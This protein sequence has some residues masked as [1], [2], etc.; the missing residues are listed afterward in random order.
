MLITAGETVLYEAWG[1]E[2]N[3]N[4]YGGLY[5]TFA[6]EALY[7]ADFKDIKFSFYVTETIFENQP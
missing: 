3:P 2:Y 5:D 4:D 6:Y 1:F 7:E